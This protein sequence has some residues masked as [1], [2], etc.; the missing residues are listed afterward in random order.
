MMEYVLL[1]RRKQ[2]A[3]YNMYGGESCNAGVG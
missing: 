1:K 3:G 2:H